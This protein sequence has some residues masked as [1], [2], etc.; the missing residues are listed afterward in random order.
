MADTLVDRHGRKRRNSTTQHTKQSPTGNFADDQVKA[1]D[2][3][4]SQSNASEHAA[5]MSNDKWYGAN[6]RPKK[7]KVSGA[8]QKKIRKQY[9]KFFE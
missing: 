7:P 1:M 9:D 2:G 4:Y 5:Y 8:D 3:S 6:H